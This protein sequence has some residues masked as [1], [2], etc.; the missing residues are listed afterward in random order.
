[1]GQRPLACFLSGLLCCVA[2]IVANAQTA[3]TQHARVELLARQESVK[4][5]T[6]LML[7]LHFVLEPGWHIYWVN[8]GDSGQ[9]PSLKWTLPPGFSAGEIEWPRPERMQ[10]SS[11]LVDYGYHGDVLLPV[12]LHA[13]SGVNSASAEIRADAKWLICREV[14]IPEHAQL[15][16]NLPATSGAAK[17]SAPLF[18]TADK[19]LPQPLPR[20]WKATAKSTRDGFVLTIVAGKPLAKA[21]FFPLDP[22]QIENAAPQKVMPSST[23]AGIALK[24]SDL[25][26]KPATVLRGVLSVPGGPAYRIEAP[27][28]QSLQ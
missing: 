17:A 26:S 27:I 28:R 12:T 14:C 10:P 5:G 4:P 13:T 7:G 21:V 15:R 18:A 1:M 20:G 19:L 2:A 22:D 16:L 24:K 23:G 9:P 11:Q 25:S 6:D 3:A 8:P